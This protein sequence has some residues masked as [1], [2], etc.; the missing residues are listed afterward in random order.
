MIAVVLVAWI[1]LMWIGLALECRYRTRQR[2]RLGPAETPA[3]AAETI[4]VHTAAH[5]PAF[6]PGH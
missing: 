6:T 3:S 5:H 2:Y 1:A 4:E